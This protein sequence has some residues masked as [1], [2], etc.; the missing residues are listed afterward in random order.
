[1][2]DEGLISDAKYHGI[3]YLFVMSADNLLAKI[4]DPLMIG[5]HSHVRAPVT[6]KTVE[7]A[8]A[9]EALGIFCQRAPTHDEKRQRQKA[10]HKEAATRVKRGMTEE[11]EGFAAVDRFD[12]HAHVP[13]VLEPADQPSEKT[14]ARKSKGGLQYS[15][16]SICQF[17]FSF[18]S[19]E[20]VCLERL[21]KFHWLPLSEPFCDWRKGTGKLSAAPS[22]GSPNAV[23]LDRHL[24]DCFE[25]FPAVAGL[26]VLRAA[27]YAAI[28]NTW[29]VDSPGTA[30]SAMSL[31]HQQWI[32]TASGM[33]SLGFRNDKVADDGELHKCEISPLVSYFGEGLAGHFSKGVL[34]LPLHLASRF[35]LDLER[36]KKIAVPSVPCL[37]SRARNV[38]V[39]REGMVGGN[40]D[41]LLREALS[42]FEERTA[43]KD[44]NP[45][46][47]HFD[48]ADVEMKLPDTPLDQTMTFEQLQKKR[49]SEAKAALDDWEHSE[50]VINAIASIRRLPRLMQ[51]DVERAAAGDTVFAARKDGEDDED[52]DE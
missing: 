47:A 11:D 50:A 32:M 7:R 35:E 1:M 20:E 36:I 48:G 5:F 43:E 38:Y 51:L 13:A 52:S 10:H 24:H 34:E 6:L 45:D 4:A 23:R 9:Y 44:Q 46:D 30:V 37:P 25:N 22:D 19:F 3:D 17:V 21:E 14:K 27:E 15:S 12:P 42:R 33:R 31:L 28:K 49:A 29:G 2:Y 40:E 41:K 26:E 16:A 39:E 8:T 18:A